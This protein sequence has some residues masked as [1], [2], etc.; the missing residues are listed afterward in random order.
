MDIDRVFR[1]ALALAAACL[2]SPSPAFAQSPAQVQADAAERD[3]L[4][5]RRAEERERSQRETLQRGANVFGDTA[6]TPALRAW[7]AAE[8]PCFAIQRVL[9]QGD[10]A[11]SFGWVLNTL[12]QGPDAAIGRCLGPEGVSVAAARAQQHLMARGFVTSRV[13][14]ESQDLSGGTLVLTLLPGRISAIRFA[15]GTPARG[16][17]QNTLPARPGDILNLRDIEQALENLRRVPTVQS[18]IQITPGDAPGQSELHIRWRQVLPLRLDLSLDDGG[19]HATGRYQGSATIGVDNPLALNDVLQLTLGRDLGGGEPGARGSRHA[20]LHHSLPL[21]HWQLGFN[22]SRHHYFQTV[23]GLA[24]DYRYSGHGTQQ[25]ATLS[26]GVHRD[27]ASKT[28]VAFKVF[29]R[30]SSNFIDDTE[31]EVQRRRTGGWELGAEHRHQVGRHRLDL[32]A[33]FKRGTGAFGALPA[34]EEATGEGRSRFALVT[35]DAA[36][37]QAMQVGGLPMQWRSHWR[38]QR[39][40]TPLTPQDRFAIGGRHSVRGF[41][42]ERSLVGERGWWWRNELSVSLGQSGQQLYAGLDQGRVGGPGAQWLAGRRLAGAVL[43]LRGGWEGWGALSYDVFI[44]TPL[45]KP[46]GFR[47]DNASAGFQL[48]AGF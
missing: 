11:G 14:I 36:W 32:R 5:Q 1:R 10:D 27:G 42:G 19:S 38:G 13:L 15:D 6:T 23:A 47:T 43:G 28:S 48:S 44:G 24:Q 39:E 7:P 33:A 41:D 20:S 3:R 16:T 31:V 35:L 34:A 26:R 37:S 12:T 2:A 18:D 29:A 9:L 22:A 46:E 30:Q 21:G 45:H 25:D 40:R 4:E 8:A 17:W